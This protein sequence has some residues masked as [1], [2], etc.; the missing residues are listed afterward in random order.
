MSDRD[1]TPFELAAAFE[2]MNERKARGEWDASRGDIPQRIGPLPVPDGYRT[3]SEMAD[4][5]ALLHGTGVAGELGP[6]AERVVLAALADGSLEAFAADASGGC[7]RIPRTI[8]LQLLEE[9]GGDRNGRMSVTLDCLTG[10]AFEPSYVGRM[11]VVRESDYARL[12]RPASAVVEPG[13]DDAPWLPG[14]VSAWLTGEASSEWA[15]ARLRE[16]GA[17]IDE[18]GRRVEFGKA[19][20]HHRALFDESSVAKVRNRAGYTLAK[21]V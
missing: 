19:I 5:W 9:P 11:G 4:R 18:R 17:R 13:R 14:T 2:N 7:N 3:L 20:T 6:T 21:G 1:P 8:W 15:N 16:Q 12:D 10:Q